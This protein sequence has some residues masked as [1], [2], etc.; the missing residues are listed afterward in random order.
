MMKVQITLHRVARSIRATRLPSRFPLS[1]R[2]FS[3]T[4]EGDI[5]PYDRTWSLRWRGRYKAVAKINH[6]Q[7]PHHGGRS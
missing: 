4:S 5:L 2:S 3:S 1:R 6:R 7:D